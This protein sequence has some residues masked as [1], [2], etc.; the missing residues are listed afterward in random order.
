MRHTER[1]SASGSD[2]GMSALP[3]EPANSVSPVSRKPSPIR[4]S[5]PGV[6]PGA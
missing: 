5:E 3:T 2:H 6:C 1:R 4:Q